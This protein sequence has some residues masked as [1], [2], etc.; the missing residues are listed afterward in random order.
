MEVSAVFEGEIRYGHL[1]LLYSTTKLTSL[2]QI[3][4]DVILSDRQLYGIGVVV[5]ICYTI[6]INIRT[7]LYTG[8]IW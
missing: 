3:R 1:E 6:I 2:F 7:E 8:P 4:A 5:A